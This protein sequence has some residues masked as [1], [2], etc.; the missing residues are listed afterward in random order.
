MKCAA[1]LCGLSKA[2]T[3]LPNFLSV[4]S[5]IGWATGFVF[6]GKTSPGKP[7]LVFVTMTKS[8]ATAKYIL[9]A[10]KSTESEDRQVLSIESQ[11]NELKAL[12]QGEGLQ[13]VR[14]MQEVS[15][16]KAARAT[17]VCGNDRPHRSRRGERDP[18]LEARP[19]CSELH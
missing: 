12:A 10:R 6:T 18:V 13:V 4:A 2:A 11:I 14:V 9:Y 7:D 3:P 5:S 1:A 19:A 15:V 17:G 16:G 8:P